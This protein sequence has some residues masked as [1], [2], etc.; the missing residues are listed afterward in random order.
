MNNIHNLSRLQDEHLDLM[1]R[2]TFALE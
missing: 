1:L 2:L